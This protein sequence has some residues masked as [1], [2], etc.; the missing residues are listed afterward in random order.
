LAR[1]SRLQ[2]RADFRAAQPDFDPIGRYSRPLD[3]LPDEAPFL[4]GRRDEPS[5]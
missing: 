3:K 1:S 2:G 5:L 4:V